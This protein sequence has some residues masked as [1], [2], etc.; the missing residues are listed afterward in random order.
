M[1]AQD[2]AVVGIAGFLAVVLSILLSTMFLSPQKYAKQIEKVDSVSQEFKA[3]SSNYFNVESINPT[4][5]ITVNPNTNDQ[6]FSG[7]AQ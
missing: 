7:S 6:L 2:F 1:K 5:N 4:Q 3:P